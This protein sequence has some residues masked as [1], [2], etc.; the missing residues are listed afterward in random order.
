MFNCTSLVNIPA[1]DA[2]NNGLIVEFKL[3]ATSNDN[4]L[5]NAHGKVAESLKRNLKR[6]IEIM[7]S[8][9]K[10]WS[11]LEPMS[12]LLECNSNH[13]VVKDSKSSSMALSMAL[14]NIHRAIEGKALVPGLSGT[15][16][17]RLDGSFD[18]SSLEEQKYFA[19]RSNLKNLNKF[20]TP[21]VSRDLFELEALINQFY[22]KGVNHEDRCKKNNSDDFFNR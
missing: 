10:S 11:C 4:F 17:L 8:M 14:I 20:I 7:L 6:V 16:I 3:T 22:K 21:H 19:A 1:Y 9:Q 18:S 13:F 15:G 5:I 12:Y 2:R